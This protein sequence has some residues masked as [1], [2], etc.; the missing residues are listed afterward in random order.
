M[1]ASGAF[2]MMMLAFAVSLPV[3]A[4][5]QASAAPNREASE[6]I[7]DLLDK[8]NESQRKSFNEGRTAYMQKR[9]ADAMTIH[10][11]LLKDFP[12]DPVLLKFCSQTALQN[13]DPGFAVKTL[14]PIVESDPQ[15]WQAAAL[16]VRACA[17]TGDTPCRDAQLAHLVDL[18]SQ[19]IT[20][21]ALREVAVERIKVGDKELS[22]SFSLIPWGPYK[23][24]A[25]GDVKDAAGKLLVTISLESSDF[26]QGPFAKEHPDDAAKGVRQ[27]SLDAYEETGTNPSGQRTQTHY[28]YKFF[29]GQP[30]YANIR[31]EFI[32]VASGKTK[33]V[34]S[35]SGLVVQ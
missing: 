2:C 25:A 35:R 15:D 26:D 22:I 20:P 11:Q 30:P 19:A 16:L 23:T 21:P 3:A 12:G 17:E 6:T 8:M 4:S 27:F 7:A 32:D 24:Y 28:T 10:Q 29:T 31:E 5:G 13:D 14:K 9:Y 18:H 1:R 33:P 34:S